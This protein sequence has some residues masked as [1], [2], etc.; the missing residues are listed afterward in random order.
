[1]PEQNLTPES[2]PQA[3]IERIGAEVERLKKTPEFEQAEMR[4]VVKESIKQAFPVPPATSG[5]A[6]VTDHDEDQLLPDYMKNDSEEDKDEVEALLHIALTQGIE[7]GVKATRR[8]RE[9]IVDD[10]HDAL[11]DKVMPTLRE[12][13]DIE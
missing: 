8:R 9:R 2:F 3:D 11:T 5:A 7:A 6:P 1:M 12:R 4:E 13:G 10:F